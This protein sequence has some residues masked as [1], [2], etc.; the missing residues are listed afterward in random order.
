MYARKKLLRSM[1]QNKSKGCTS[2]LIEG[3][4]VQGLYRTYSIFGTKNEAADRALLVPT[5][6]FSNVIRPFKIQ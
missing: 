5:I 1:G 6:S 3:P 2:S 4:R